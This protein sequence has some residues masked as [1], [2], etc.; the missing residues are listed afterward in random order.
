MKPE[1]L[2]Y[3][4]L[5]SQLPLTPE[6]IADEIKNEIE[7]EPSEVLSIL[8]TFKTRGSARK[9]AGGWVRR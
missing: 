5:D 1:Q 3:N 9:T 2:V 8:N 6:D 7:L 4:V